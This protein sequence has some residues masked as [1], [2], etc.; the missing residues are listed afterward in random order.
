VHY[1]T[2]S[3]ISVERA[4][5]LQAAYLAK[6]WRLGLPATAAWINQPSQEALILTS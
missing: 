2:A 5:T 3:Q 4:A 6:R 1:G